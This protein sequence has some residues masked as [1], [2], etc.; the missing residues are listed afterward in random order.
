[1]KRNTEEIKKKISF[2]LP[3]T[4]VER[5]NQQSVD[6]ELSKS[7]VAEMALNQ[8]FSEREGEGKNH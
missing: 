7:L 2:C 4:L 1:M 5:V 6:D 8:Y 3:I